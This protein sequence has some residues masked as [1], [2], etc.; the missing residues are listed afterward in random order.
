MRQ[1]PWNDESMCVAN[2]TRSQN[3]NI[4][5]LLLDCSSWWSFC[6]KDQAAASCKPFTQMQ[7][8]DVVGKNSVDNFVYGEPRETEP[9]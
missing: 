9:G 7:F 5:M 6:W 4:N 8:M 2:S 3:V 1:T